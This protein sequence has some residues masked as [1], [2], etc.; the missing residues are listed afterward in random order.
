MEPKGKP[1]FP[2]IVMRWT[3]RLDQDDQDPANVPSDDEMQNLMS[4]MF[5][6]LRAAI[7]HDEQDPTIFDLAILDEQVQGDEHPEALAWIMNAYHKIQDERR[8]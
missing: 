1:E 2:R 5:E 4:E 7:A 3:Q 6:A 8:L